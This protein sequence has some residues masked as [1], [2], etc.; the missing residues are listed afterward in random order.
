MR[1]GYRRRQT[2]ARALQGAASGVCMAEAFTEAGLPPGLLQVVTG[3]GSEIGDYLT[4]H[5]SASCI[6]FTGGD[7]GLKISAQ[8]GMVPLQMEL[9]G[10]DVCLA[11]SA[12]PALLARLCTHVRDSCIEWMSYWVSHSGP[13]VPTLRSLC[14]MYEGSLVKLCG[15]NNG[16][17]G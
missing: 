17:L 16:I 6:S 15:V 2:Q 1:K 12:A 14:L 11:R 3:R 10:K 7:T 13:C 8:A 4:G 5:K 9:G